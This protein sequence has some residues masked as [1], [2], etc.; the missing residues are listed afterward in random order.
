[1]TRE[2]S[3]PAA[4]PTAPAAAAPVAEAPEAPMAAAPLDAGVDR[5]DDWL[6]ILHN[7]LSFILT[8]SVIYFYSSLERFLVIFGVAFLLMAYHNG[9]LTLQRRQVNNNNNVAAPRQPGANAGGADPPEGEAA[10]PG[11]GAEGVPAGPP[12]PRQPNL[13]QCMLTF[14]FTFFTSLIPERPRAVN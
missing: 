14:I 3:T 13:F 6:G 9:W 7:L 5:D 10:A 2:R 1:M 12:P 8:F 11:D 4:E